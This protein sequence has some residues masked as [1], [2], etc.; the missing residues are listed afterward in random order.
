M[1]WPRKL[2]GDKPAAGALFAPG[3][4]RTFL[5]AANL[6]IPA[7]DVAGLWRGPKPKRPD[8]S[9]LGLNFPV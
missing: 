5:L 4:G 2:A 7:E 8:L 3:N 1:R 6:P 9:W